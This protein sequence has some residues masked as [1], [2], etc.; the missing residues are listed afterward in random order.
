M[1]LCSCI[2]AHNYCTRSW[3]ILTCFDLSYLCIC[4][5]SLAQALCI[6]LCRFYIS[7]FAPTDCTELYFCDVCAFA[8]NHY[9]IR[10]FRGRHVMLY[11][12]FVIRQPIGSLKLLRPV[13]TNHNKVS[14]PNQSFSVY[15]SD[16]LEKYIV[17]QIK[18]YIR[19]SFVK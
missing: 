17:R 1:Y 7:A 2:R 4:V 12:W 18:N 11:V 10:H 13:T 3:T 5:N 6:T 9:T 15:S 14:S 8:I 19:C 16:I